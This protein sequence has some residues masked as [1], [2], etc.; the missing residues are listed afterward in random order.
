MGALEASTFPCPRLQSL[1]SRPTASISKALNR[2][3]YILAYVE[4]VR[5]SHQMPTINL[6]ET[7]TRFFAISYNRCHEIC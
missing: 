4:G 2:H 5:L 3:G 6:P 1:S 7:S